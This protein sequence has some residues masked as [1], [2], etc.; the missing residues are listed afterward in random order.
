MYLSI[1]LSIYIYIYIY[2]LGCVARRAG[3]PRRAGGATSPPLGRGM[4]RSMGWRGL[5]PGRVF[6][7]WSFTQ[8]ASEGFSVAEPPNL[9]PMASSRNRWIDEMARTTR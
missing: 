8:R 6:G 3:A 4:A 5:L 1:Y 2:I 7:G 9:R